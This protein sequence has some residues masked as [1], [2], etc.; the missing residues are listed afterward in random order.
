MTAPD[1]CIAIIPARGGS[2]RLPRKNIL[3]WAGRPLVAHTIAIARAAGLFDAIIVSTEDEEIARIAH[4]AGASVLERPPALAGDTATVVQVCAHVLEHREAGRFCCI[5]ATA[6][7][8]RPETIARAHA[9]LD[10]PPAAN[11][12]MG[13]S[14]YNYPPVQ[15]LRA[16]ADGFLSYMWPEFRGRQSQTYPELCVSNGTFTWARSAA[17][18]ADRIFYAAGLR[19]FAVPEDEVLDLD[20]PEDYRRLCERAP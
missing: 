19:G 20:T 17:F 7:L 13:V 14:R 4:A 2:K 11:Y 5:Y 8:L 12:V 16:D 6:V 3:P 18:R 15:A 1:A 10:A 9:A